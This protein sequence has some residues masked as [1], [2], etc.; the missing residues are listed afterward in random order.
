MNTEEFNDEINVVIEKL[1]YG[2]YALAKYAG[3]IYMVKNAYPGEFVKIVPK[4]VNKNLIFADLKEVIQPSPKRV[5]NQCSYFPNCGG[6]QW[7]DYDYNAQ[8]EAKTEIIKEQLRRIGK[9]D[10]SLVRNT[11]GSDIKYGYRNRMEFAFQN[12]NFLKLGL[13][14][15]DSNEVLDIKKCPISP[16]P[17]DNIKNRFKDLVEKLELQIYNPKSK[18]GILKYLVLRRSFSKNQNM[19]IL[20]THT[21][22]LPYENEIKQFFKKNFHPYSLIH[23]MNSSDKIVLRGPYRTLLGEGVLLEEFDN[24]TFQIPPTSF[25]Q[26]NY[27][28]TDKLLKSIVSYLKDKVNNQATLLDLYSGVGL[29]SI[30]LSPLFKHIEAVENSKISVKAA[31]SNSHI[32]SINNIRFIL[33]NS[34]KYLQNNASKRFDFAIVDPPRKGLENK[35]IELLSS[36]IKKSLIYVS[37][38]P[39][40]LARDLK[41]FVEKGF[42]IKIVQPFDMFPHSYHIESVAILEK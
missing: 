27:N 4:Q 29:F 2:G 30:Y 12:N 34:K 1:V 21:E 40:T 24:F 11:I 16:N 42:N 19:I 3:K 35:E 37:C 31:I 38:D 9:I 14:K 18:K 22:Y 32:N 23:L 17:F 10:N 41:S 25:F 36:A 39:S 15:A 5:N 20:V 7:L 8:I 6:C 13:K 33:A 28:V 26:N